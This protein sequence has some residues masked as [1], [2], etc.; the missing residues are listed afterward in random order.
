MPLFFCS[1]EVTSA[2]L[3]SFRAP[4]R[5]ESARSNGFCSTLG[6]R[7]TMLALLGTMLASVLSASPLPAAGGY[8]ARE[9]RPEAVIVI[10]D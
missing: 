4:S 3:S 2:F 1:G 8:L 7:L 6:A 9:G 10:G 5:F